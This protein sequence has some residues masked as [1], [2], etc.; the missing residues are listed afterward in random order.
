M[1][2]GMAPDDCASDARGASVHVVDDLSVRI[3]QRPAPPHRLRTVDVHCHAFVEEVEALVAARPEKQ[4]EADAMRAA[5]GAD[6][7]AH[8]ARCM[9]PAAGARFASL[10]Q[11][12]ADMDAMGVDVQVVSPSPAQYYYWA[13]PALAERIGFTLNEG[14]ARLCRRSE[15]LL[16]LGTVGLQHGALAATQLEQAMTQCGLRG[17]EISTHVEGRGLDDATLEPFWASAERLGAVVFI[18]PFGT[19]L[20]ARLDRAYLQNSIGQPLETAIALSQL[21]FGGVLDRYPKLKILAAHGGGYLPGYPGRTAHAWQVRPEARGAVRNPLGYLQQLWFDTLVHDEDVLRMLIARVGASRLV[22]G[23][24][25]PFDMGDY[26]VH[27]LLDRL[28]ELSVAERE[29]ILGGNAFE[30]L[31]MD[32]DDWAAMCCS[33]SVHP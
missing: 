5:M 30:L 21:I 33:A 7:A 2:R 11:R 15:R 1:M 3:G 10:E 9:L 22:V 8:N 28:P 12:L 17:V 16:G 13:E 6:S 19:T 32:A 25:Y 26:D 20:G 14:I 27:G 4:R 24:D 23:T 31:G 29:S 18:H